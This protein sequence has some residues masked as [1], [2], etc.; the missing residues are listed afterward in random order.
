[1]GKFSLIPSPYPTGRGALAW[2]IRSHHHMIV[3]NGLNEDSNA[4]AEASPHVHGE[5]HDE[6]YI[7][8]DIEANAIRAS[9]SARSGS[10]TEPIF[11]PPDAHFHG[12]SYST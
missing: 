3:A 11:H 1:M 7:M 4:I 8:T 12:G 9:G 6:E 10:S 5:R 2:G